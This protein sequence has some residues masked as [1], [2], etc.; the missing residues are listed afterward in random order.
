MY[1]KKENKQTNKVYM[2]KRN[3]NKNK[4]RQNWKVT[5]MRQNSE[6]DDCY[7]FELPTQSKKQLILPHR[8]TLD[9]SLPCGELRW[10]KLWPMSESK[11]WLIFFC[12]V[13]KA[14]QFSP[15]KRYSAILSS[16]TVLIA[17]WHHCQ[18]VNPLA[19]SQ[20]HSCFSYIFSAFFVVF[21]GAY[22]GSLF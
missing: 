8:A 15:Q 17:Q 12:F 19:S 21:Q 22:C 1:T 6:T 10:A 18:H 4:S 2:I 11:L 16:Y 5:V 3:N 7:C 9:E 14:Q 13:L 20:T